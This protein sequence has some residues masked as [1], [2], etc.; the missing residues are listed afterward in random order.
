MKDEIYLKTEY[1]PVVEEVAKDHGV[2][3]VALLGPGRA[4]KLVQ[5]RAD[6]AGRLDDKG[7]SSSEIGLILNRDHTSVLH[8]LGRTTKGKV[9]AEKYNRVRPGESS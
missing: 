4:R 5:A 1:S 9:Y 3:A 7:L 6:L 2:T 8:L